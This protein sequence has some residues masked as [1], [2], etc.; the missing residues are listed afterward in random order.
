MTGWRLKW[1][2][3]R[4][5]PAGRVALAA[6]VAGL[7]AAPGPHDAT[8]QTRDQFYEAY[9]RELHGVVTQYVVI[10]LH[11]SHDDNCTNR[12]C[13]LLG[14][15]DDRD[16]CEEWVKHYNRIDPY[17]AARCLEATPFLGGQ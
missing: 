4:A 8:A 14:P 17:D 12:G 6:L 7:A 16:A 10:G 9:L 2:R 5:S 1:R 15:T 13:V 3:W 11:Y